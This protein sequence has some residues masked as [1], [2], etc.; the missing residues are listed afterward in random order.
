[1]PLSATACTSFAS[2]A[3]AARAGGVGVRD[4]VRPATARDR[5]IRQRDM[6]LLLVGK[7]AGAERNMRDHFT[8]QRAD[9]REI[10]AFR[11]Q[12]VRIGAQSLSARGEG[13]ATNHVNLLRQIFVPSARPRQ[14]TS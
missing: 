4:S 14:G 11:Y 9:R 5:T 13:R 1:M 2:A 7:T 6:G 8:L 3:S 12:R 10:T